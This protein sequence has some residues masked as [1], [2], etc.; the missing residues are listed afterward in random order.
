M[1]VESPA[2]LHPSLPSFSSSFSFPPIAELEKRESPVCLD[3]NKKLTLPP[4]LPPSLSSLGRPCS[5]WRET[6]PVE[7]TWPSRGLQG[8]DGVVPW[9]EEGR[10]SFGGRVGRD[11]NCGGGGTLLP[12]GLIRGKKKEEGKKKKGGE[13]GKKGRT[14]DGRTGDFGR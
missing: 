4:S 3:P 5:A 9:T 11:R 8:H 1:F 13:R 7:V 2:C 10:K 14:R 12:K 6:R